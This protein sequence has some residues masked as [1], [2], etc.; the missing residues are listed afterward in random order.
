M[1]AAAPDPFKPLTRLSPFHHGAA[2]QVVKSAVGWLKA[3]PSIGT[4][5]LDGQK[6][7]RLFVVNIVAILGSFVTLFFVF[8]NISS[9]IELTNRFVVLT[10]L[11]SL[12]LALTLLVSRYAYS[13][14]VAYLLVL[15]FVFTTLLALLGGRASGPH[16]FLLAAGAVVP[17][18]V[19]SRR[20]YLTVAIAALAA[21]VFLVVEFT[22]PSLVYSHLE[23]LPQIR[24]PFVESLDID[25]D[26]KVFILSM[27]ALEAILAGS[28]FTATRVAENAEAALEREHARSEALL[29]MLLPRPIAA[30]LK[31]TPSGIIADD[32]ESV[33]IL[34]ADVV[35]FT[36][37]ASTRRPEEVVR[38]LDRIFGE[39]DALAEKHG[40]EKIKTIGDCYMVAGGMPV[41]GG[42][43]T[44]AIADMALG[45]IEVS[46]KLASEFGEDVSVRIGFHS[47]P[48]VAGVI[49]R[50]KPFYDVWGD[51]IN[52]AARMESSGLPGRIQITPEV[53]EILGKQYRFEERGMVDVKGK[54]PMLLYF[55]NGRS[56]K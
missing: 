12:L 20:P 39:F 5:T 36:P 11:A 52:V 19:G 54:G 7:R 1:S 33:T 38:F 25:L 51:T 30:R 32:F 28:T 15:V 55:L 47:G 45:M 34:F 17:I 37:R 43:H 48:A 4:T 41:S 14:A 26:D 9:G 29:Q 3:L 23:W 21:T 22:M 16:Y 46:Q 18:F 56:D 27:F 2:R 10:F 50:R 24:N 40:L 6:A 35:N 49:G 31:E 42:D 8:F 53:K 13:A 44:S